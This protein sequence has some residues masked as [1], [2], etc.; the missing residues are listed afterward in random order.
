MPALCLLT[1]G[2]SAFLKGERLIVEVPPEEEGGEFKSGDIPLRDID[3]VTITEHVAFTMPALAECLRRDIPVMITWRGE[4]ILG[5]CLP[6]APHSAARL[7]QYQRVRDPVFSLAVAAASIRTKIGNER[8]ILQRIASNRPGVDVAKV[9]DFL[10][11]IAARC[12]S[13]VSVDALRGN[14]GAAAGAYFEALAQFFPEDCPFERR[15]RRPP[16][17]AANALLSFGYTILGAEIEC[18]IVAAGLDPAL[19]FLHETEDR[20]PS[21]ALDLMEPFRAPV[22]DGLALDLLGHQTLR[23]GVHFEARDGGVYL[24]P[25]GRKRFFVGYERRMNRDFFSEQRQRRTT[26]RNELRQEC[27][28]LK[29]SVVDGTA[30]EP[31]VMN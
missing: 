15:S 11:Q 26:L 8:R 22:A 30:F 9:L 27:I 3:S 24:N 4:R 21:L 7:L 1:P 25:E 14:E 29:Q 20:R 12:D 17:N 23:P 13:A 28:L 16:H 31:F 19:G 2:T 6:P 18:Q 5:T 10:S